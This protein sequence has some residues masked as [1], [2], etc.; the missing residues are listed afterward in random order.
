MNFKF[1]WEYKFSTSFHTQFSLSNSQEGQQVVRYRM[2]EEFGPDCIL[3][4]VKYPVYQIVW[5]Y[6]SCKGMDLIEFV[7]GIIN[8]YVYKAILQRQLLSTTQNQYGCVPEF[9]FQE[10]PIPCHK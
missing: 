9:I 6:F 2:D 8:T 1:I 7:H 4:Q 10:D 3:C 5:G